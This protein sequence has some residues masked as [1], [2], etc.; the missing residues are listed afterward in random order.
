[1]QPKPQFWKLD[2]AIQIQPDAVVSRTL[3]NLKNGTVTL[4]S[5]DHEQGLSEHT[6]PYDALV[7]IVDGSMNI[8][9]SGETYLVNAG[10]MILMPANQPHALQALSPTRMLLIMIH[11]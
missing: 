11:S 3:I 9:V 7:Q 1:M 4:F 8:T 5:F 10:E 2:T 6:T